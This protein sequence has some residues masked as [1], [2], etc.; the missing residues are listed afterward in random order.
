[1]TIHEEIQV[2]QNAIRD[3][4]DENRSYREKIKKNT[5]M[6]N[7]IRKMLKK[8]KERLTEEKKNGLQG[9]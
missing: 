2:Y 7:D 8:A 5:A 9:Y 6:A 4:M 3:C 1:M